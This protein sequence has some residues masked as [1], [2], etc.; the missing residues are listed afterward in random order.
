MKTESFK[1]GD[2]ARYTDAYTGEVR[3]G[4]ISNM[5]GADAIVRTIDRDE[6]GPN[7]KEF[8]ARPK[9]WLAHAADS[10]PICGLHCEPLTELSLHGD[11]NPPGLG[12][13]SAGV[14]PVSQLPVLAAEL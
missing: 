7:P 1:A 3:Y 8:R 4:R 14:C 5:Y 6:A 11:A 10:T 9:C 12:H 13:L 2:A